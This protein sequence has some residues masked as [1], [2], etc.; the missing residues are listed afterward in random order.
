MQNPESVLQNET[1]KVVRNFEIETTRSSD[2]QQQQQKKKTSRIVD[3]AVPADHKIKLKEREKK[4][5]T[6]TFLVIWKKVTVIIVIVALGSVTKGLVQ[7]LCNI[8][9]LDRAVN[10]EIHLCKLAEE[11]RK[12]VDVKQQY[13][14]SQTVGVSWRQDPELRASG[15]QRALGP[16]WPTVEQPSQDEKEVLLGQYSSLSPSPAHLSHTDNFNP[17]EN[18]M[19]EIYFYK[20]ACSFVHWSSYIMLDYVSAYIMYMYAAVQQLENLEIRGR[21]ETIQTT[22]LLRSAWILRRVLETWRDLQSLKL[23]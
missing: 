18:K 8:L 6:W 4:T 3:F 7:G 17:F 20:E 1:H 13:N 21:T 23:Q 12:Q 14:Q 9:T 16:Q 5:S 22:T 2:S 19:W 10:Q 15:R 11:Q